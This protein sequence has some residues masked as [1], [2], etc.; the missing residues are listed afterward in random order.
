MPTLL[1]IDDGKADDYVFRFAET[2]MR[3]RHPGPLTRDLAL[4]L[5]RDPDFWVPGL[6]PTA[7]THLIWLN[8]FEDLDR[9]TFIEATVMGIEETTL[10][11]PKPEPRIRCV[12]AVGSSPRMTN[13]Q[14]KQLSA[15]AVGIIGLTR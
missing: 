11:R 14:A 9:R 7:C 2:S 12:H 1:A 13:F 5:A 8:E 4:R 3:G 15:R 10:F 6:R